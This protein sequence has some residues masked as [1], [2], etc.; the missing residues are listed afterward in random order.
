MLAPKIARI[1]PNCGGIFSVPP[2]RLHWG[3]GKYCSPDCQYEAMRRTRLTRRMLVNAHCAYCGV[4]LVRRICDVKSEHQFC[5]PACHYKART[6]GIV[7]RRI[8][9]PYR[10]KPIP[11]RNCLLCGNSYTTRK[12]TQKFCSPN[13]FAIARSIELTAHNSEDLLMRIAR[14]YRG[15]GWNAI[16]KA[17]YK[18]DGYRCR[19]CG[20]TRRVT[21][22]AH[23]IM[24]YETPTDNALDNLITLCS[25]CHR[26]VERRPKLIQGVLA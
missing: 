2:S 12:R 3:R 4:S 25:S 14:G 9:K 18:R 22:H 6:V 21:L 10:R 19:L 17:V 11:V 1:C 15:L 23:H 20:Q 7:K 8:I 5:S 13:C 24:P 26:R 16:R